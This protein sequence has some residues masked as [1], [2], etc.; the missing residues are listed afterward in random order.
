MRSFSLY[1]LLLLLLRPGISAQLSESSLELQGYLSNMQSVMFEEADGDW[2]MDNLFHN[3][4]NLFWYGGEHF[5][6]TVQLRNRL[7][8]GETIK[9]NPGYTDALEK[10]MGWIDMTFNLLSGNSFLLNSTI[11]R[12]WLQYS[13]G[14]FVATAG[15]QRI[16]WGQTFVWNANDIFNTYSYFDFDY[17]ERP[18]S[19]AIRLQYYPNYTSTIELAVK[20]DS[21]NHLTAAALYRLNVLSYD[22]QVLAGVLQEE[23][24]VGGLGWSG[25]IGGAGFRGEASYF[26]PIDNPGDTSGMFMFSAGLEY[27][28]P[29]T[30]MLQAEYL[31]S[32]NPF[33]SSLGFVDFYSGPLSVKQ[34]AFTEHS[35]FTSGSYQFT[36]LFTASLAGMYFPK[37]KG[38]FFGPNLSYNVLDNVDLGFFLQYFNAETTDPV[39]GSTSRQDISMLFLRLK[40][41]F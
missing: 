39:N 8:Y 22:I 2:I 32:S 30:L 5:S 12:L 17:E 21:A 15:R 7:M 40:W 23:D 13:A 36:P 25:S 33:N 37:M 41:N 38:F 27:V 11:D 4:L 16:N 18:G 24:F 29:N 28:F 9:F 26:H 14:S 19:D 6:G 20:L 34:L 31:Y 3:R 35:I 1:I 10:D